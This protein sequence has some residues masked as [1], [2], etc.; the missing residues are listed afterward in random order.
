M[1]KVKRISSMGTSGFENVPNSIVC[2][3]IDKVK[4]KEKLASNIT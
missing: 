4:F 3:S 1:S 2:K